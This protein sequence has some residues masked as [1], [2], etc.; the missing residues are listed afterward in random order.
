MFKKNLTSLSPS[1]HHQFPIL[2]E[3]ATKPIVWGKPGKLVIILFP[4]YG[5]FYPIRFPS[6]GIL[7]YVGNARVFPSISHNINSRHAGTKSKI[8]QKKK[9]TW[10]LSYQKR[11]IQ[12]DIRQKYTTLHKIFYIFN[13]Q[14]PKTTNPTQIFQRKAQQPWHLVEK[15]YNFKQDNQFNS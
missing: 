2:R 13:N 7:H 11:E 1:L 15:C 10:V 4:K 12:I 9:K 3:N 14:L 5:Y 6:Y 8:Y